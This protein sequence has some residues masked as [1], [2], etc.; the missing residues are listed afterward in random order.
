MLKWFNAR[1]AADVGIALADDFAPHAA[2]RLPTRNAKDE[3]TGGLSALQE[4]LQRADREVRP[5]EL[6]FYQRARFANAFKWR[7]I[8]NGVKREAA[9]DVTQSPIVHLSQGPTGV[10]GD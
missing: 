9:D 7:L 2:L 3:K 1:E 6:N 5:L 4:L 10:A 8:E